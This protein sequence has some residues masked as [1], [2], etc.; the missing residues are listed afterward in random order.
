MKPLY[1]ILA[2]AFFYYSLDSM[3]LV[4]R[5]GSRCCRLVAFVVQSWI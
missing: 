1:I 5:F 3:V 4:E 2:I